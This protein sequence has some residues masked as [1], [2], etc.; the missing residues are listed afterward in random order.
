MRFEKK[1]ITLKNGRKAILRNPIT[2]DAEQLIRHLQIT[3]GETDFLTHYPE[4]YDAMTVENEKKWI[5]N[6]VDSPNI[7]AIC[8]EV[9][10]RIAGTCHV[11]FFDKI[12]TRHRASVGISIEKLYWNLGIGSAMF[13]ELIAAAKAHG[14]EIME[15]E[16]VEGNS[17]ARHL[18]EKFGFSVVSEKPNAFKLKD[19]TYLSEFYMQKHLRC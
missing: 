8:C 5:T 3:C 4:E 1:E 7:L 2:D 11:R 14:T 13:A 6:R 15:L 16:F 18:Y 17:R 12:K 19:G 10:G 9:E